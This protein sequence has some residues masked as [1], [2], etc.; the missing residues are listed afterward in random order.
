MYLIEKEFEKQNE[1]PHFFG[2]QQIEQT[3]YIELFKLIVNIFQNGVKA[4]KIFSP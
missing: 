1:T 3:F 4:R 2:R